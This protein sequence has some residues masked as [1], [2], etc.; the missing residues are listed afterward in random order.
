MKSFY[1]QNGHAGKKYDSKMTLGDIAKLVRKQLKDKFPYCKWSVTQ[2]HYSGGASL[3]INLMEA[4]FEAF[5]EDSNGKGYAQINQYSLLDEYDEN[6]NG[7]KITKTAYHTLQFAMKT[8][9]QYNF[10]DCDSQID[11]FHVNFYLHLNIG[12]WN[13]PFQVVSNNQPDDVSNDVK[14]N[15]ALNSNSGV[16]FSTYKGNP[17]ISLPMSNNKTFS[18]GKAKAKAILEYYEE[19]KK[20]VEN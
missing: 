6:N 17:I 20:F 18:F 3:N 14:N 12:K 10:S 7:Y 5:I 11:Y 4:P 1:T 13:K 15:S 9:D 2:E 16:E 8:A 19:I